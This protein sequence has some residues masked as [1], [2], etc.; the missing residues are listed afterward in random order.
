MRTVQISLAAAAFLFVLSVAAFASGC[1]RHLGC[2][3]HLARHLGIS[4]P[5]RTLWSARA[6]LHDHRFA[7]ASA[8]C[9]GCVVVFSRGSGGHVGIVRS[10]DRHGNV[11]AYSWGNARVGWF[12][13]TYRRGRVLGF[14]EVTDD[15]TIFNSP[16]SPRRTGIRYRYEAANW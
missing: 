16:Q 8:G 11:V 5:H 1:P 15:R 4:D 7:R 2:G 14:R 9:I 3:C 6:W 13:K 12:T 10:Y